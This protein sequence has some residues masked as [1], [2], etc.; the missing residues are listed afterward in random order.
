[1]LYTKYAIC[2]GVQVTQ[3]K[4]SEFKVPEKAPALTAPQRQCGTLPRYLAFGSF[5]G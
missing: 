4:P 5:L 3:L 2:S 1:M